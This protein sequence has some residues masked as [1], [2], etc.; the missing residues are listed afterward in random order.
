MS[1]FAFVSFITDGEL[2]NITFLFS[3]LWPEMKFSGCSVAQ[4]SLKI[5]IFGVGAS[6]FLIFLLHTAA[7]PVIYSYFD[8]SMNFRG[9]FLLD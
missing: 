5:E 7:H 3:F 6:F 8:P 4:I 1:F 2:E 9:T